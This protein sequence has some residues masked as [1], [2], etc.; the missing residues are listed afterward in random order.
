M[1]NSRGY[2]YVVSIA[3]FPEIMYGG[4]ELNVGDN[5]VECCNIV[6]YA[7]ENRFILHGIS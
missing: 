2:R 4:L 5:G 7:S 6:F 1:Q 3:G